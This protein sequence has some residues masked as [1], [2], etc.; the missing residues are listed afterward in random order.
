LP[1][2]KILRRSSDGINGPTS[3]HQPLLVLLN[4]HDVKKI[5]A[6]SEK[7]QEAIN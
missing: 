4:K 5:L 3:Y 1:I 2:I 6:I 7:N